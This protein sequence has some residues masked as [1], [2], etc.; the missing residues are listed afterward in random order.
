MVKLAFAKNL[1]S[2]TATFTASNRQ[3]FQPVGRLAS[4]WRK[5]TSEKPQVIVA[6]KATV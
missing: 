5:A 1:F 2:F 3:R 6:V 4:P